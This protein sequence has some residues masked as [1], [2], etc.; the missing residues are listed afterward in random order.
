M[1]IHGSATIELTN[2]DGSKEIIKH[3]NMI[4]NAVNDLLK[5]R[6]GDMPPLYKVA[7]YRDPYATSLFGGILLFDDTLN[8]D[9]SDYSIPSVKITGYASQDAYGGTDVARGGYNASE[10]GLQEDG[11]YKLVWDFAT[12][13][14]NGTI[15]SLALCP[16]LMGK[17]GASETIDSGSG[18]SVSLIGDTVNP[19]KGDLLLSG[20]KTNDISNYNYT[21][22]AV[23]NGVAYAIDGNNTSYDSNNKSK[24]L[25]NNGGVLNLY[26]FS[27]GVDT[28]FIRDLVCGGSYIDTVP[29]TL[30]S[31]FISGIGD[32]VFTNYDYSTGKLR[33]FYCQ[34]AST[35]SVGSSVKYAEID[36]NTMAVTEH[37][38]TNNTSVT[39]SSTSYSAYGQ[40]NR[41]A[42]YVFKDYI[43]S[44]GLSNGVRKLFVT[45]R[46]DNTNVK[47]VKYSD[48]NAFT[49]ESSYYMKPMF[50]N[51]SILVFKVHH[52]SSATAYWY[53]LDM[54]TGIV[55]GTNLNNNA[56]MNMLDIGTIACYGDVNPNLSLNTVINPF[57]LTTKNNLDSP[58]TKTANQ[59]MKITYTLSESAGV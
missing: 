32:S 7:S 59:T 39:I 21:V 31:N 50:T 58:V 10:S 27:I 3:D 44:Q 11:S 14:A 41:C 48:T 23:H 15:K 25:K 22:V 26:R 40:D 52:Y 30:P 42:F 20:G 34:L 13:Q 38:F 12:S 57:V 18:F 29:V 54:S 43:V 56:T 47:E 49:F 16:N 37:T 24:Y 35:F 36:L 45:S 55:K 33:V 2:A 5:S 4:T 6:R 28:V 53:I 19:F 8:D 51:G 46:I 9:A 17:I 1:A